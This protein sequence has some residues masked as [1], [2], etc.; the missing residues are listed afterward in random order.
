MLQIVSAEKIDEKNGGDLS[1]FHVPFQSY[2]P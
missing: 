1:S 2:D